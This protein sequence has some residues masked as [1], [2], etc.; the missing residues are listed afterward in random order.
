MASTKKWAI[1]LRTS[2]RRA[3]RRPCPLYRI[4]TERLAELLGRPVAT[5]VFGADMQ[6]ELINNGPV[7]IWMD[8]RNRE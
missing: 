6:V 1:A 7:T 3:K 8:S 5:G 4:F 2:A